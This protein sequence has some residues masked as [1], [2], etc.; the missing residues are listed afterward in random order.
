MPRYLVIWI[1]QSIDVISR[2]QYQFSQ[3]KIDISLEVNAP[4]RKI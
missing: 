4:F 2:S 3:V 1:F